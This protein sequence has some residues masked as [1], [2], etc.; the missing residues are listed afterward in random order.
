MKSE[1]LFENLIVN[2]ASLN[3]LLQPNEGKLIHLLSAVSVAA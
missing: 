1:T 2:I 3:L